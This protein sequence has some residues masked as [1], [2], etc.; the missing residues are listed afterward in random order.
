MSGGAIKVR[1][2]IVNPGEKRHAYVT[3]GQ[4]VDGSPY[5]IPLILINGTKP[6]PR[7]LVSAC[8]HGDEV[9][10]TEAIKTI[11]K[12]LTPENMAGCFIGVPITNIASY[13]SLAR[14]DLLET[15]VG[16]NDMSS[17]W[18][19]ATLEGSMT[20]R[21]AAFFTKELVPQAEYYIEI[22]SSAQGSFNCPRAIV[23]SGD[24]A[25]IDPE[26]RKKEDHLAKAC[27]F[28][29]IFKPTKAT[30]KG[31]YF[32]PT[33]FFENV[34]V[35]RIILETG[36]APTIVDVETIREGISN[37]MKEIRMIPGEASNSNEQVYCPRLMAVR[38][39][40]GGIFRS[41]V[42]L[43]DRVK[44]GEKL[45]EVTD[46]FDNITEELTAPE[47]GIVVKVATAAA[48]YTGIRLIVLAIP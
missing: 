13:L 40:S 37:I 21:A 23:Y 16:D 47:D 24:F 30:W 28:E 32:T 43:R 22:H 17:K 26:I 19:T 33:P 2:I 44:K 11:A 34:G 18:R 14:V 8:V 35:A 1:D 42:K 25:E 7:L 20:E 5:R 31:M 39:N 38:A 46:I 3:L 29:V 36:G 10:G 12:T 45:G 27:N 15:P 6:G 41:T 9:I 4:M 48:V